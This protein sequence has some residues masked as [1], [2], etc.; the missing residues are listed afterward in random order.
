M[1]VPVAVDSNISRD[2]KEAEENKNQTLE[3]IQTLIGQKEVSY[4]RK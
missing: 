4:I 3:K 2:D 1:Y